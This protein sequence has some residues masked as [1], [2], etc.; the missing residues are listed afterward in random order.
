MF[1]HRPLLFKPLRS[2]LGVLHIVS[3]YK[4]QLYDSAQ[5]TGKIVVFVFFFKN[6]SNLPAQDYALTLAIMLLSNL[7]CLATTS[8]T[9]YGL[10]FS[11][12]YP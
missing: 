11:F 4:N 3:Q 6:W 9:A 8:D 1:S 7:T 5:H 2:T 10:K 12:E